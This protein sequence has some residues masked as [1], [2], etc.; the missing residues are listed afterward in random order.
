MSIRGALVSP[1]TVSLLSIA[2]GRRANR[3]RGSLEGFELIGFERS[4]VGFGE[5]L[6][7]NKVY[8]VVLKA[9]GGGEGNYNRT[10]LRSLNNNLISVKLGYSKDYLSIRI[11]GSNEEVSRRMVVS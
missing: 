8:I 7:R 6:D 5:R 11:K 3:T 1:S 9:S 10:I 2:S 4:K